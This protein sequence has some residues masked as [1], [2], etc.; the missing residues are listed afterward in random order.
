MVGA[1]YTVPSAFSGWSP[2]SFSTNILSGGIDYSENGGYSANAGGFSYG[3]GGFSF[4]PSI[5]VGLT[6]KPNFGNKILE[7]PLPPG[8]T[9]GN[10]MYGDDEELRNCVEEQINLKDLRVNKLSAYEDIDIWSKD[11]NKHYTNDADG[12]ISV[13]DR[14]A[15]TIQNLG[16]ITV[17]RGFFS[18]DIHMSRI[19]DP[20]IFTGTLNHEL[21]HAFHYSK[22]LNLLMGSSF[23]DYTER[24]AYQYSVSIGLN[25]INMINRYSP[26]IFST[27]LPPK[28][29]TL[30]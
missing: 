6:L 14:K 26:T 7:S 28:L 17:P 21:I 3:S 29:L 10:F 25:T 27:I 19:S 8:A 18:T 15:N 20:Y 16:G 9:T 30:P 1:G 12:M 24:I 4:N 23:N 22:G 13:L 2:V 5:G 11:R